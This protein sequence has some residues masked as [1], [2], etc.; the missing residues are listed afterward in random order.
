MSGNLQNRLTAHGIRFI[1]RGLKLPGNGDRDILPGEADRR[2]Q[3]LAERQES[4]SLQ[5]V[6]SGNITQE[7]IVVDGG[8]SGSNDLGLT[9]YLLIILVIL[10]VVMAIIVA[11]RLMRS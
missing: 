7:S 2:D 8:N 10:I 6:V 5:I 3:R 9:D 1:E 11:M 4:I